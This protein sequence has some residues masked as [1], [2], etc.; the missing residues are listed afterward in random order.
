MKNKLF[1]GIVCALLIH[2]GFILLGGIFFTNQKKDHASL[3]QVELFS[4]KEV[5]AEKQETIEAEEIETEQTP[6]AEEIINQLGKSAVKE[7][8]LEAASLSAIEAAL[9]GKT[10]SGDFAEALSFSSGG[11]IGGTGKGGALDESLE[12]AFSL[13]EIDQ[14]PRIIFQPAPVYPPSLRSNNLEGVVSIL[15]IVDPGGR[16]T[17]PRVEKSS[18]PPFEKPAIDAVKQ[19]K[20]EPA[21][22]G[23]QRVACKMRIP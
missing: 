4:E 8:E 9:N 20:F 13:T 6:D 15:F 3:Q 10:G 22:K 17:N 1:F 18:H 19:W 16:V 2:A 23:G 5:M 12:K 7:P 14:K 11:K 21:I